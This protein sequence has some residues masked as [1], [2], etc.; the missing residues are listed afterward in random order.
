MVLLY[1]TLIIVIFEYNLDTEIAEMFT[2]IYISVTESLNWKLI[3]CGVM[4]VLTI[5]INICVMTFYSI[6]TLIRVYKPMFFKILYDNRNIF[7]FY[8]F[9]STLTYIFSINLYSDNIKILSLIYATFIIYCIISNVLLRLLHCRSK[10]INSSMR[11]AT[12]I[13]DTH[14]ESNA[15]NCSDGSCIIKETYGT[16][17]P[18]GYQSNVTFNYGSIFIENE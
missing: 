3:T 10:T 4:I 7:R 16:Y 11:L 9:I 12:Y 2:K 1:V 14:R 13:I 8:L 6:Y 15:S 17:S 5:V 18:D